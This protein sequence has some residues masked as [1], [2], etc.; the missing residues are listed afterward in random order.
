[1]FVLMF[2]LKHCGCNEV[3]T[4]Q[5]WKDRGISFLDIS[6]IVES[7]LLFS[8]QRVCVFSMFATKLIIH[9]NIMLYYV[10]FLNRFLWKFCFK[11]LWQKKWILT[12]IF[13]VCQRTKL[14]NRQQ[15]KRVIIFPKVVFISKTQKPNLL[16]IGYNDFD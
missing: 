2:A 10:V 4:W 3:N 14:L 7:V 12:M 8:L 16:N 5:F 6:V 13:A 11:G 15:N 9:Y 1:M